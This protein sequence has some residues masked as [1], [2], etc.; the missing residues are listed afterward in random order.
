M[1]KLLLQ[2]LNIALR[3]L[4]LLLQDGVLL[5]LDVVGHL[6]LRGAFVQGHEFFLKHIDNALLFVELLIVS[7]LVV[8]ELS[9]QHPQLVLVRCLQLL[10][11]DAQLLAFQILDL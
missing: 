4:V 1:L 6:Y 8:L 10:P 5:F 11:V 3:F 9:L 2:C 7:L